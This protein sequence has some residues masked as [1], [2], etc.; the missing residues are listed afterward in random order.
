MVGFLGFGGR[1]Q[2]EEGSLG[3]DGTGRRQVDG[4]GMWNWSEVGH[5]KSSSDL[6]V[7]CASY[8]FLDISNGDGYLLDFGHN[9]INNDI[10]SHQSTNSDWLEDLAPM[11]PAVNSLDT[12][13]LWD[14]N[15]G[16][17]AI[18]LNDRDL[19][20]VLPVKD[21]DLDMS[22]LG[23]FQDLTAQNEPRCLEIGVVENVP[24]P[25]LINENWSSWNLG[26]YPAL[27]DELPQS[28]FYMSA[29]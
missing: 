23:L 19:V 5:S 20:P 2:R 9:V 4:Q 28:T 21:W 18:D 15:P 14:E 3:L 26:E 11:H 6:V 7:R 8:I 16:A 12:Y 29:K 10:S 25:H 13:K 27:D 1:G 17:W 22:D 24:A